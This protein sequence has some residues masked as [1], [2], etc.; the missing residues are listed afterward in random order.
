M[1]IYQ[2]YLNGY[3]AY[4]TDIF[5]GDKTNKYAQMKNTCGLALLK[6]YCGIDG[7]RVQI[8]L[9]VMKWFQIHFSLTFL[10]KFP[11]VPV[12]IDIY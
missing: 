1:I 11:I 10:F 4:D 6:L 12:L 3:T 8:E 7:D 2:V 5:R 9:F